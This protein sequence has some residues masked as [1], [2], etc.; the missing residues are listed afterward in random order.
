LAKKTVL[1]WRL[2]STGCYTIFKG[3]FIAFFYKRS[4]AFIPKYGSVL[5]L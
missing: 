5:N 3:G 2:V 1:R 4:I